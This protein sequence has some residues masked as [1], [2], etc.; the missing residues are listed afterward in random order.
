MRPG[1]GRGRGRALAGRTTW[2]RRSV[3]S[4]SI[5]RP[6]WYCACASNAHRC[7]RRGSASTIAAAC[8]NT[9]SWC[10]A[11]R[12]AS[13]T[14]SSSS[15]RSAER[16][17]A[18]TRPDSQCS[19]SSSG[20]PRQRVQRFAGDVARVLG[21]AEGEQLP[22]ASGGT[23]ELDGVHRLA[24]HPEPV[25]VGGG[26]DRVRTEQL[27]QPADTA[28]EVLRPGGRRVVP[29]HGVGELLGREQLTGTHG[30]RC[31]HDPV[32]RPE[33]RTAF[34][35]LQRTQDSDPHAST[36]DRPRGHVKRR[37]TERIPG[38]RRRDTSRVENG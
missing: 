16:R 30:Q 23:R 36:V 27:A 3:R 1:R 26:L 18:S 20:R 29:P 21:L 4:A 15:D 31:E 11:A 2:T 33:P 14:V 35:D 19:S 37:D 17:W 10:P 28:L 38:E 6:A 22:R 9:S 12:E 24:R 13:M 34:V 8:A 7:S 25:A 32:T 5:C